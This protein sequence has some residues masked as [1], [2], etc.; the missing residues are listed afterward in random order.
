MPAPVPPLALHGVR[1]ATSL[2]RARDAQRGTATWRSPHVSNVLSLPVSK[3][4]LWGDWLRPR[5]L[6][7]SRAAEHR[8]VR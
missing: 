5:G 6:V 2:S 8:A 4:A 1:S 3:D 7:G